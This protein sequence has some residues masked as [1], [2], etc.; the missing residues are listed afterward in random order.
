MCQRIAVV[1]HAISIYAN[2]KGFNGRKVARDS[3]TAEVGNR[4]TPFLNMS[5]DT[6]MNITLH[7][8]RCR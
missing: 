6:Y 2:L 1:H 8:M 5:F 7:R 3:S 4:R